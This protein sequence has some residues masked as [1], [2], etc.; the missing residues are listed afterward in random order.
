MSNDKNSTE[1]DI[2]FEVVTDPY[3]DT[4]K[5][6]VFSDIDDTL[7]TDVIMTKK[8][9]HT[10]KLIHKL[11]NKHI[12]FLTAR[13]ETALLRHLTLWRL[14]NDFDNFTLLMGSFLTVLWYVFLYILYILTFRLVSYPLIQAQVHIGD[15]KIKKFVAYL[16]ENHTTL[17]S[18]DCL[19]CVI[20]MGDNLQGDEYAGKYISSNLNG[21]CVFDDIKYKMMSIVVIRDVLKKYTFEQFVNDTNTTDTNQPNHVLIQSP[22]F[23]GYTNMFVTDTESDADEIIIK[24]RDIINKTIDEMST[25]KTM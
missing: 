19:N 20:F 3:L 17:F 11:K 14:K 2:N 4:I 5:Y 23:E 6:I 21:Y 25:G 10:H 9:Q 24:M 22:E 12:V 16:Q 18:R 13:P 8:I 7:Y 1:A 15:V